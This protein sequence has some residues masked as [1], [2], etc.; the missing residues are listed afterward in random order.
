MHAAKVSRSARL[1]RVLEFL[2]GRGKAGATTREIIKL[3]DVCA[4]N[5]IVPELRQN[6]YTISCKTTVENGGRVARYVLSE[7]AIASA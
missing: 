5:A 2:R 7:M 1:K 3:C 6:G 4:V